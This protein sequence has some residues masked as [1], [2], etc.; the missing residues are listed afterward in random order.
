MSYT[1]ARILVIG[2]SS[3]LMLPSAGVMLLVLFTGFG[4]GGTAAFGWATAIFVFSLIFM[5]GALAS[6]KQRALF[7]TKTFAWYKVEHADHVKK[8]SIS[9]F[10]CGGTRVHVRALMNHTYHREHFCTQ[11]GKTLYYSPEQS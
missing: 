5:Y 10:S 7:K 6:I 1:L 9:C 2:F 11:C 8:G 4:G 3:L